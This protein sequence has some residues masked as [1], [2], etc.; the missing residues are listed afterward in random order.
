MKFFVCVL[1][2]TCCVA[3]ALALT[4]CQAVR[5]KELKSNSQV[6]LVP[7]CTEEGE[8]EAK[9]CFEGSPFCMCWRPDG[10]H[11]TEPSL[12]I[13]SCSCIVH[14]DQVQ[15]RRLVGNYHPQCE[16]DGTYSRI[17]CHGGM[18]FCWCV[19]ENGNKTGK[20]LNEC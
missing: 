5:E 18:G 10:S 8:Y 7:R 6:K 4:E 16:Q 15:S 3:G 19:D 14:R 9:Q 13:K 11:I 12:K 17:Q 1:V 2:A 20:D